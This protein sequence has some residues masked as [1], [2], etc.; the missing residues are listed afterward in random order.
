MTRAKDLNAPE[1]WLAWLR[2]C[3][4]DEWSSKKLQLPGSLAMLTG[5]DTRTLGA[6]AHC[7]SLYARSDQAGQ[8]GALAAV[9][10]LLPA[11]QTKCH[12]FAREL[13]A[14]SLDW[15]DR[16]RLWPLVQPGPDAARERAER[17]FEGRLGKGEHLHPAIVSGRSATSITLP[18]LIELL[19][20]DP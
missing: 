11:L 8:S 12:G 5:Q 9:R 7:W 6:V 4:A 14:Q 15:S 3:A 20:G 10:A 13:I 17:F 19:G 2:A 18:E 16:D 1:H